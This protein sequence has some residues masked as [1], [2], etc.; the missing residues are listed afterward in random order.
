MA[1]Y[2]EIASG[3]ITALSKG[4]TPY[5]GGYLF[6]LGLLSI[7]PIR[8][9]SALLILVT[10]LC[11]FFLVGFLKGMSFDTIRSQYS[12]RDLISISIVTTFFIFLL[13][14]TRFKNWQNSRKIFEQKEELKFYKEL[15]TNIPLGIFRLTIKGDFVSVNPAFS[16]MCGIIQ[17]N[18]S[19]KMNISEVFSDP[20]EVQNI[21]NRLKSEGQISEVEFLLKRMDGT[22]WW[23]NLAASHVPCVNGKPEY[24]DGIIENISERKQV[25]MALRESERRLADI[26]NFLPLATIVIDINGRVTAWN[27][28]IEELTGIKSETIIGKGNYEYS[29]PFYGER[30]PILID[31][32]F[33]PVENITS[34]YEQIHREGEIL[35]SESF[36]P[37]LG[38]NGI[39]LRGFA[40]ALYDSNGK[41][42]GAIESIQDITKIKRTEAELKDAKE[43]AEAANQSKSAFLANM[44]HE[45]RTPMNAILGFAEIISTRLKDAEMANYTNIIISSGNTL[46][47]II[48]DILDL[49]KI[50]AGKLE[51]RPTYI[52]L[53]RIIQEIEKLFVQKAHEKG[54]ELMT[55]ISNDFPNSVFLDEVRIRQV[56]MNLMGNAIKFS[57]KG[58]VK[59]SIAAN[60]YPEQ[61]E[62]FEKAKPGSDN[63]SDIIISIEDTGIGIPKNQI[64]T[65]F[66]P[67]EQV[68]GQSTR[69]FGGT[70][71]GLSISAKLV[72][73]MGGKISLE[74]EVGKG[75]KF[76]IIVPSIKSGDQISNGSMIS[77]IS[78]LD[79]EFVPARILVVDDIQVNRELVKAY[80]EEYKLAIAETEDG[81]TTLEE[82]KKNRY[83]LILLDRK[84]P[85]MDGE[86]VAKI[87]KEDEKT[88][89]IPIVMF[90]ASALKEEE[91]KIRTIADSFLTKPVNKYR[92]IKEI[93]KYIPYKEKN[94][95]KEEEISLSIPVQ[96]RQLSKGEQEELIKI[97]DREHYIEWENVS[98]RKAMGDVK[99]FAI[100]IMKT[101]EKYDR[102]EL[103]KYSNELLESVNMF[104]VI[105]VKNLLL[106][107]PKIIKRI[108]SQILF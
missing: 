95:I 62:E 24:I 19:G 9:G 55:E 3:L 82:I 5:I 12:L 84:M 33:T 72:E 6:V 73:M 43:A 36:I 35:I 32:V 103:I 13:N 38:K 98:R 68:E 92:L 88:K 4:D 106:E 54:L 100:N 99:N 53:R 47:T 48:N 108:I 21:I 70:G 85:G 44:S 25:E 78:E 59:I 30:K 27:H 71:L 80:L 8:R 37:K 66:K 101:A 86:E 14:S 18:S 91:E 105:K 20:S 58:H 96:E 57:N 2:L 46:L 67:F 61:W 65:I 1:A 52:D 41:I 93:K 90:T 102:S 10:S 63:E 74:S 107:Y 34:Y 51:L 42:I 77:T 75:S 45:I 56:I 81:E 17:P 79:I 94:I 87:L 89:D 69:K 11:L 83:D 97:L 7:V 76:T 16:R 64:E 29:L 22:F 28:S 39:F 40:T 50:E 26:I 49:S 104:K 31:F 23:G 15:I 60:C